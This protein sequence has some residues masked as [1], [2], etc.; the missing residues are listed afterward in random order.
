MSI[1]LE[2]GEFVR[3]GIAVYRNLGVDG[4]SPELRKYMDI[5]VRGV[6]AFMTKITRSRKS[7]SHWPANCPAFLPD[8]T[9]MFSS[10]CFLYGF[11]P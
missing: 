3:D 9:R 6:E 8:G 11:A 5:V 2:N 1:F 4:G 7:C 10:I